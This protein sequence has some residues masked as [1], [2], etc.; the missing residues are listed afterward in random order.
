METF[1]YDKNDEEFEKILKL[2]QVTLSC[3]KEDL[4]QIIE[5]LKNVKN[6]SEHENIADGDHWHYRD[7]ID[8]WTEEESDLIVFVDKGTN[9]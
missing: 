7:Y 2:S 3:K 6:E 1:G 9:W 5:F 4:D 8:S